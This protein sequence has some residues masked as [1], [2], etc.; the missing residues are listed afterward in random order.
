MP[1]FTEMH[2][3][4]HLLLPP[5]NCVLIALE[6]LQSFVL[7]QTELKQLHL[8]MHRTSYRANGLLSDY[9]G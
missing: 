5:C 9:I 1:D 7:F 6:L 4:H 3:L 8:K 2:R